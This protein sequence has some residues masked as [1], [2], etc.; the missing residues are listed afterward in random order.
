MD[1]QGEVADGFEPVERAFRRN[2]EER[3]EWGAACAVFY[4]GEC[5]VDLWGGYRDLEGE[6]PWS[7]D[8]LVLVFSA[9]KG[10]AAVAMAVARDRGYFAYDDRVAEHWEAFAEGGKED[11]TVRELLGHRAGLAAIDG[12]LTPDEMADSGALAERLA[13]KA[14]DWEP[15]TRHGYHAW[16][17]G[18]YESGLLQATDPESRTLG[19]FF[20]EEVA[21]PMGADIYIGLPEEES[22]RVSE[23]KGIGAGSLFDVLGSFP[24]GLLLALANPWSMTTRAMAP[25]DIGGP[26]ELNRPE[27]REVEIPSGNGIVRIR[28]LAEMYGRLAAGAGELLS[29]E[30]LE[31]LA[32]SPEPPSQGTRDVIVRT[33]TSYHLGFWKSCEGL[34]L[35]SERAFGAPGAGGAVAFADPERELGFA[36]APNRMGGH[37]LDDPRAAA[38]REG[39]FECVEAHG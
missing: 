29:A 26:A 16:S 19:R 36:Y 11:V 2:F 12:T 8:T 5:V 32:E 30:T 1:I 23:L 37:L 38:L 6:E 17:L 18:W 3:D 27:Y 9:T 7:E 34:D 39:A 13:S 14:P 31:E 15:G 10:I 33:E 20:A 28:D 4:R 21:E 35:C 22:G 24:A 25:F